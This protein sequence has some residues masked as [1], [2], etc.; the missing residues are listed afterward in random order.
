MFIWKDFYYL[1]MIFH[2]DFLSSKVYL[3]LSRKRNMKFLEIQNVNWCDNKYDD[4]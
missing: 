4:T 3:F 2:I 1:T